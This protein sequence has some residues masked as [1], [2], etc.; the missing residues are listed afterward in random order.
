MLDS[1][2]GEYIIHRMFELANDQQKDLL[3][4]A[5]RQKISS[6]NSYLKR[7]KWKKFLNL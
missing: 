5:I 6:L 4:S 3:V 7:K 2:S 1:S